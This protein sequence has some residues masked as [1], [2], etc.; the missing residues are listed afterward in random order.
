[1]RPSA[2]TLMLMLMPGC[3]AGPALAQFALYAVARLV[4]PDDPEF[5]ARP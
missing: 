4:G 3:F 2:K 5:R 1:M